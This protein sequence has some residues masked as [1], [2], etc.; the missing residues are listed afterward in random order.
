MN[1][2]AVLEA[3]ISGISKF[4]GVEKKGRIRSSFSILDEELPVPKKILV[5]QIWG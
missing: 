5:D 4:F 1:Y 3:R 2:H